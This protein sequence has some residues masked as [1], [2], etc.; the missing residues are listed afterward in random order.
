M[1]RKIIMV[2]WDDNAKAFE[3]YS[4]LKFSNYVERWSYAEVEAEIEATVQTWER[5]A[6]YADKEIKDQRRAENAEKRKQKW[7]EF[8]QKFS[9]KFA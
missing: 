2:T 6:E 3:E 8:K 9:D 1:D 7:E 4:K 5:I